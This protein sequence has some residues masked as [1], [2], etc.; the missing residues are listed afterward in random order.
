M[1]MFIHTSRAGDTIFCTLDVEPKTGTA[2]STTMRMTLEDARQLT[3]QLEKHILDH[4][5]ENEGSFPITAPEVDEHN[6]PYE[7]AALMDEYYL[8]QYDQHGPLFANEPF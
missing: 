6:D 8:N 2:I 1:A 3:G 7:R 4:T 5:I